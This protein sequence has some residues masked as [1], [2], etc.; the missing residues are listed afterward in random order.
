[1]RGI[2]SAENLVADV[3]GRVEEIDDVVKITSIHLHYR[4]KAPAAERSTVDRVLGVYADK[5][6]AYLSVKDSIRCSWE[7][8]VEEA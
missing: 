8:E 6:P 3:E 4:L 2:A 1:M 7:V 5:C